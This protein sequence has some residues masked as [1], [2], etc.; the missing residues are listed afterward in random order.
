MNNPCWIVPSFMLMGC[1][2]PTSPASPGERGVLVL[3]SVLT[4]MFNSGVEVEACTR[5][6][7]VDV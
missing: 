2:V 7:I 5:G 4:S 3:V 1:L 6:W